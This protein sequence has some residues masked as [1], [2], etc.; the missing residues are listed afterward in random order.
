MTRE[1]AIKEAYG[2]LVNKKQHEALQILIPELKENKDERI[3]ETI[4]SIIK[5]YARICEK[6]G[7]PCLELN[8]CLTYLEKLK[9]EEQS[10]EDENKLH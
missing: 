2:I 4:V 5:Q 10:E 8:D 3:R 6:E 9:L 7:D 1:E